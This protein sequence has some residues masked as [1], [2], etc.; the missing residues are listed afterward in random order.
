MPM[1]DE[2][3]MSICPVRITKNSPI[4]M[5]EMNEACRN[6]VRRLFIV[7]NFGLQI[8]QIATS[9]TNRIR[10]IHSRQKAFRPPP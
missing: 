9:A 2:M 6:T 3:D 5:M 8:Q 1:I 4:A 7:R 10:I